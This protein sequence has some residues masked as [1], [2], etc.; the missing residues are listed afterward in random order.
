VIAAV[1]VAGCTGSGHGD[2][3]PDASSMSDAPLGPR[4]L[5]VGVVAM[6]ALPGEL[7]PE[8]TVTA[9]KFQ[10]Q[11]LQVIGDNGQPMTSAAFQLSW[12]GAAA[13]PVV[14]FASA[15]SGL[16]SQVNINFDGPSSGMTYEITGT[17]RLG[18]PLKRYRIRDRNS[19]NINVTGFTAVL[20][21][22]SDAT[23]TIA[24]DLSDAIGSIR[25]DQLGGDDDVLELG[26]GNPQLQDLRDRLQDAFNQAP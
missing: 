18:G 17:T 25:F 20:S 24:L 7:R 2:P 26:P 14:T 6:P 5:Y 16:Y 9:A 4:G 11:R 19:L 15:P 22:G 13:P 10:V 23:L 3:A 1:L 8:L 21:P 12:E